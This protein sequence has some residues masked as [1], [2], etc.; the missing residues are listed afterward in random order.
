MS[1][2]IEIRIDEVVLDGVARPPAGFDAEVGRELA[3]L[4]AR[5]GLPGSL[6]STERVATALPAAPAAA[7]I[8]QSIYEGIGRCST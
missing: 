8:A 6:R 1:R 2:R 7:G 3:V 5:G 4:I